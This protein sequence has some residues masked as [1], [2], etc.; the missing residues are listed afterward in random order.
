MAVGIGAVS[1]AV[2]W[3]RLNKRCTGRI[4]ELEKKYIW[5]GLLIGLGSFFSFISWDGQGVAPPSWAFYVGTGMLGMTPIFFFANFEIVYSKSLTWKQDI[6]G[7]HVGLM[8]ALYGVAG[9]GGRFLGP[10][11]GGCAPPLH[12]QPNAR[13]RPLGPPSRVPSPRAVATDASSRHVRSYIMTIGTPS[14]GQMN[15]DGRNTF[16]PVCTPNAT[17]GGVPE[18]EYCCIAPAYYCNAGC[19]LSNTNVWL[20]VVIGVGFAVLAGI[21]FVHQKI[22]TYPPTL[23]SDDPDEHSVHAVARHH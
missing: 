8:M 4:A 23:D 18:S 7:T 11:I 6:V 20:G 13:T 14:T 17:L 2:V 19:D 1:A 9:A 12:A 10:F 21:I 15:C 3:K 16:E 5:L 22:V